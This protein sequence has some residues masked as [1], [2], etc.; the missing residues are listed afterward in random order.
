MKFKKFNRPHRCSICNKTGHRKETCPQNKKKAMKRI[1]AVDK[2]VRYTSTPAIKKVRLSRLKQISY[3]QLLSLTEKA[4]KAKIVSLKLLPRIPVKSRKCF[5]CGSTLTVKRLSSGSILRCTDPKCRAKLHKPSLTFTP[6]WHFN[7]GGCLRFKPFLNSMY[8]F[9]VKIP[10]DS[11]VHMIGAGEESVANHFHMLRCATA[12]AELH[13]GRATDFEDGTLEVDGTKTVIKRQGR[14]RNIHTGRFLVV[15]HKETKQYALEPLSDA[16]VKKGAPPPP[17]TVK[18]VKPIIK[19]T[20]RLGHVAASDSAAAF[21]KIFKQMKDIPHVHVV[22]KK[23]NFAHVVKLPKKYLHKRL[24]K[25]AAKLPTTSSRTYRV[26][27]G[28][29]AAE[30]TFSALKRNLTRLNLKRATS[31]ASINFLSTAWLTKNPG[32]NGVAKGLQ[33]YQDAIRDTCEPKKAFKS[34]DWLRTLESLE[35]QR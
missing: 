29:N 5:K 27:A 2:K 35:S 30:W 22:H 26:K 3:P 4:A 16:A 6:Y 18:E 10:Q 9:G 28:G 14:T 25:R 11:G 19:K 12:F 21:K 7:K 33:I 1:S 20:F 34:L 15:F 23:K 17:E 13:T 32:L 31:T 24:W 8:V